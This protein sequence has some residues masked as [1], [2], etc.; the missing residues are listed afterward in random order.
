MMDLPANTPKT[1]ADGFAFI[2]TLGKGANVGDLKILALVEAIGKQLYDDLAAA[3]PQVE[4]KQI[5]QANGRE[6]LVHAHRL[7]KAVELLTGQPF[8]IPEIADNPIYTPLPFTPVTR[9]SLEKLA[10]GEFGGEELYANIASSFDHPE[11]VE[12]LRLNGQEESQ[13]G[14]RLQEAAALLGN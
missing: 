9:E 13:H 5:L 8:P 7:S 12:L 6:E 14:A 1:T 11:V 4:V 2:S 3:T 10:L